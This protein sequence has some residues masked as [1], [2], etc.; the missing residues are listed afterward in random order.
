MPFDAHPRSR[1][2]PAM[3]PD[4]RR[5]AILEAVVPLLRERGGGV[6][7]RELATAAGVA[8]GT[9]FRV[10]P[11]KE[12][13]VR[14]A[15]ERA[16]D[17]VDLVA[18]IE[19]IPTSQA[20]RPA[21]TEAVRLMQDR[22]GQVVDLLFV[23]HHAPDGE[24]RPDPGHGVKPQGHR[25]HRHH[26]SVE[27]V[28]DAVA[29]LLAAHAAELRLAPLDSARILMGLVLSTRR[30]GAWGSGLNLSAEDLVAVALDGLAHHAS[31]GRT[32]ANH[33]EEG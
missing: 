26:A 20:L 1:R 19:A 25:A 10:F 17:P 18:Q 4:D 24:H 7:T 22:A 14:A 21:L 29:E 11:D 12:T 28:V 30:P 9:L 23:A 15:V 32:S 2:A 6:T 27:P 33:G 16:L 31:D 8:E 3:A 13:L 5:A